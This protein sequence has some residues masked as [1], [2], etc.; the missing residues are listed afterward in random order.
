[1][2]RKLLF[3]DIDGTFTVPGTNIVPESASRALDSARAAGHKAFLCTGRNLDLIRPLLKYGFDGYVASAGGYVACD[4]QVIVDRKMDPE[5]FRLAMDCFERNRVFRTVECLDGTYGDGGENAYRYAGEFVNE[6]LL[7][8]RRDLS[9]A[10]NIRPMS[11]YD[12][13][14]A[15]K[16]VF[17]CTDRS[18]LD[19]P[20]RLL[21]EYF[22]VCVQFR[23]R[24]GGGFF[25]GELY[26]LDYNKGYGIRMICEHLGSDVKDTIGFGDN[27]NDR[28]MFSAVGLSVCMGNGQ[29]ALKEL[30]DYVCP[31]VTDDGLY[32]AFKKLGLI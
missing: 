22:D 24:D 1:M 16:I 17:M 9:E 20:V 18:Q 28:G 14:P 21:S 7:S 6:N 27:I 30:A 26:G 29:P 25:D 3:L 2:N 15:Y 19:E 13:A 10:L 23:E 4:S 31:E 12:G 11:E 8:Y 5:A 32:K